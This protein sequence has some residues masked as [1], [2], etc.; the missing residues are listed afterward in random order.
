VVLDRDDDRNRHAG[1]L[2]INRS[3]EAVPEAERQNPA[4]L[5]IHSTLMVV[6]DRQGRLRAAVETQDDAPVEE[7]QSNDPSASLW[8]KAGKPRL[9]AIIEQLL[10]ER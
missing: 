1:P 9:T 10:K 8:E 3:A 4:D 5:F 7:G 2:W 6:V